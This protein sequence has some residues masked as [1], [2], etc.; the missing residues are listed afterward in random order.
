[1]GF[2]IIGRVRGL[3]L[4]GVIAALTVP[5]AAGPAA[6]VVLK[7]RLTGAFIGTSSK[8]S[9][10]ATISITPA[11][12][13]WKF[14]YRG[15]IKPGDSGMRLR[16]PPK[17]GVHKRSVFPLT[18]NT[19]M[20]P[21]CVPTKWGPSSAEW[22]QKIAAALRGSTSASLTPSTRKAQSAVR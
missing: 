13:C 17:A 7:A 8:G 10:T 12:V 14:V 15:L 3:V 2:G 21:G 18:A 20:S 22:A 6:S 11:K 4:F 16:P 19:S 5:V 9:G 1:L